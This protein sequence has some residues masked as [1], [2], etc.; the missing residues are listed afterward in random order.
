VN[1][2]TDLEG[3]LSASGPRVWACGGGKGGVG[4]S[5]ITANLAVALARAG[6]S[7]VLLDADLGGANLH[8]LLGIARPGRS[9]ADLFSRQAAHLRELLV[10]TGIPGLQLISGAQPL[11]A[12]A[13]PHH[14]Q[15]LKILR[16]LAALEV[17]YLLLDLGAG[18]AFN[19][20]DFS[21]AAA[22]QLLV[23]TPLPTSVENAYHVLKAGYFRQL[24]RLVRAAELD[25]EAGEL[26]RDRRALGIRLPGE[27]LEELQKISPRRGAA[28]AR[29]MRSFAPRILVNQAR[30]EEDR[31]LAPKMARAAG[32]YFGLP[33]TSLGSLPDD[34]RVH[35]AIRQRRAIL[36][37]FPQAAFSLSIRDLGR[38]LRNNEETTDVRNLSAR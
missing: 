35:A 1:R 34:D 22:V 7:C 8:T 26:L 4:K 19:V 6:K 16:Q 15:K 27:L 23:V 37:L 5:V 24:K 11:M 3:S 20:L 33:V 2:K 31:Q 13:N 10:P 30:S 21:L 17:D 18:S 25:R 38:R 14:A 36:E 32:D 28:V 12:M 9:L 29:G